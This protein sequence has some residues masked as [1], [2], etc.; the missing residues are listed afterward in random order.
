M[1]LTSTDALSSPV[2]TA[3]AKT[4][5]R[6]AGSD[7]DTYIGALLV[8]ATDYAMTRQNRELVPR[9]LTWKLDSFPTASEMVPPRSPL[10][11]VTSIQ[12]VDSTGGTSTMSST[13]YDVDTYDHGRIALA[14]NQT[15]PSAREDIDAVT[16]KYEAGY[17]TGS[18]STP[19]ATKQAIMIL[20]SHWYEM[21]EPVITGAAISDVP[22]SVDA[23]L[24]LNRIPVVA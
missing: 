3:E 20:A 24:D 2:T 13:A 6:V 22:M 4:H 19:D 10:I 7:D 12:Y 21:R 8:A 17:S 11:S 18:T 16:I 14:Y 15:W 5:M 1:G 23:L 9:S